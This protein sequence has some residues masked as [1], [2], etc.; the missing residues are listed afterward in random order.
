MASFRPFVILLICCR[1]F[2]KLVINCGHIST[3][4]PPKSQ[5]QDASHIRI[6][7]D[8]DIW[9]ESC[10]EHAPFSN[11]GPHIDWSVSL[12]WRLLKPHTWVCSIS[13]ECDQ[14]VGLLS[15]FLPFSFFFF[16]FFVVVKTHVSY[17][18]ITLIFDGCRRS[19]V[20]TTPTKMN[21]IQRILQVPLQDRKFCL[22]R[23][24][25]TE[26]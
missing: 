2:F 26:I 16:S 14:E 24:I 23:N 20:A 1:S 7:T 25:R 3:T 8:R 15:Q 12:G 22:R 6:K 18:N 17:W 5:T 19:S 4:V 11:R 9:R 13:G 10:P 21:M